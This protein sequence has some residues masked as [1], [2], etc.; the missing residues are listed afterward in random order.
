M[1]LTLAEIKQRLSETK[2]ELEAPFDWK[3]CSRVV[4]DIFKEASTMDTLNL[5]CE[6]DVEFKILDKHLDI[7]IKFLTAY[8]NIITLNINNHAISSIGVRKLAYIKTLRKLSIAGN[9]IGDEGATLLACMNLNTLYASEIGPNGIMTLACSE[10]I[11]ELDLGLMTIDDN[12][13]HALAVS[14]KIQKL[15]LF[16]AHADFSEKI[17][18][19][20]AEN[21]TLRTLHLRGCGLGNNHAKILALNDTLDVLELDQ[22]AI[23]DEGTIAL[24]KMP[25]LRALNLNANPITD[26]GVAAF[27][28]NRTLLRL[29]VG[30]V[31]KNSI[32]IDDTACL[33]LSHNVGLTELE[34]GHVHVSERGTRALLQKEQDSIDAIGAWP[35]Q[36][37]AF[38]CGYYKREKEFSI[39]AKLSDLPIQK[40]LQFAAPSKFKLLNSSLKDI[41]HA[42]RSDPA[43]IPPRALVEAEPKFQA[44]LKLKQ[45]IEVE[46]QVASEQHSVCIHTQRTA[47]RQKV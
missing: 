28:N 11:E 47:K 35:V 16:I 8:P 42:F 30:G 3:L 39:I 24:S 36:K 22:N 21:T 15:R 34:I 14:N 32:N 12:S 1:S 19:A 27:M 23:G 41:A 43:N 18:Q 7:I 40:I 20:F 9:N 2:K 4:Y 33:F 13:L 46:Q 6:E 44:Y 37:L 25:N 10:T 26:V 45:E 38:L 31:K 17:F 5:N 29:C